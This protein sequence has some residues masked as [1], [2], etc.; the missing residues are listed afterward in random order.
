MMIYEFHLCPLSSLTVVTFS[1]LVFFINIL[2][3][4]G[5]GKYIQSWLLVSVNVRYVRLC[6]T[7]SYPMLLL[8]YLFLNESVHIV[9]GVV[10]KSSTNKNTFCGTRYLSHCRAKCN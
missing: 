9:S 2:V 10:L 7:L 3:I 4:C 6:V 1:V 8:L 5:C